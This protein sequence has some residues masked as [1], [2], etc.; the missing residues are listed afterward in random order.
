ML[1]IGSLSNFI[2]LGLQ[3]LLLSLGLPLLSVF[4]WMKLATLSF[5]SLNF[6]SASLWLKNSLLNCFYFLW[7]ISMY[8]N[9]W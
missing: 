7:S 8:S 2:L 5:S 6:L 4:F 1:S 3:Q 9:W